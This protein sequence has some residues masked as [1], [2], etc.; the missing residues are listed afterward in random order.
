MTNARVARMNNEARCTWP[1]CKCQVP[2][3][4]WSMHNRVDFC[5]ALKELDQTEA[6][7][8]QRSSNG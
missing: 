6:E 3:Y 2:S 4:A 1:E 5:L 8:E 7:N